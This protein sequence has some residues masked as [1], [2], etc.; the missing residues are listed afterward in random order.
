MYH[1]MKKY[2]LWEEGY[3]K[4]NGDILDYLIMIVGQRDRK[5][6]ILEGGKTDHR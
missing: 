2:G 4:E 6:W 1:E 5:S 3:W